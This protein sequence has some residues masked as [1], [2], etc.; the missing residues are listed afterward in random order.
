MQIVSKGQFKARALEYLR[1]VEHK[2][3]PLV[4]THSGKPV[5]KVIPYQDS[6]QEVILKSLQGTVI[7]YK[8]PT[9]PAISPGKWDMLK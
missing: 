9:E 4:I 7:K 6:D 8:D 2:K 1:I 3:S 5:V